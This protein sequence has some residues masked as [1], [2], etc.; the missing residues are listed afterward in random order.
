MHDTMDETVRTKRAPTCGDNDKNEVECYRKL[1]AVDSAWRMAEQWFTLL[2]MWW[3]YEI[4]IRRSN[5]CCGC[6]ALALSLSR[7]LSLCIW[8]L[9]PFLSLVHPSCCRLRYVNVCARYCRNVKTDNFHL[10]KYHTLARKC[11]RR[12]CCCCCCRKCKVHSA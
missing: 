8:F 9:L 11:K 3:W 1:N 12:C 7:T 10:Y 6:V 4:L 2:I 5:F